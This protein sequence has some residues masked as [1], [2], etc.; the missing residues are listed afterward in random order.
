MTGP[1][2]RVALRALFAGAVACSFGSARATTGRVVD[3]HAVPISNASVCLISESSEV[4]CVATNSDGRYVLYPSELTT[5]RI[6]KSG[7]L[8]MQIGNVDQPTPIVLTT[9][10]ALRA[11]VVDVTTGDALGGGEIDVVYPNGSTKDHL[12]FRKAGLIARSLPSG[13]AVVRV[14]LAGWDDAGGAH[15]ELAKGGETEVVIKLRKS[16]SSSGESPTKTPKSKP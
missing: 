3:E 6:R 15:V 13:P 5:V 2:T 7:Y 11:R 14:R 10:S 8:P 1:I 9:G 4:A 12:P 16:P